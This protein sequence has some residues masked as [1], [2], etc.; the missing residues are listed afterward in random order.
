VLT[1]RFQC[2]PTA[3]VDGVASLYEPS[4]EG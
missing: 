1:N 3:I 4:L 2:N